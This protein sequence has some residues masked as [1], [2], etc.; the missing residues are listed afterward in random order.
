MGPVRGPG[1]GS[2]AAPTVL[3]AAAAATDD[4][5]LSVVE[6]ALD[7]AEAHHRDHVQGSCGEGRPRQAVY[8]PTGTAGPVHLAR[9]SP[10][11]A[12][13]EDTRRPECNYIQ[14]RQPCRE[15]TDTASRDHDAVSNWPGQPRSVLRRPETTHSAFLVSDGLL[16]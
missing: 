2:D 13:V 8:P 6:A 12:R 16:Y 7:A 3:R 5:G 15:L 11:R 9:R 10:G 1:S 4:L 14:R